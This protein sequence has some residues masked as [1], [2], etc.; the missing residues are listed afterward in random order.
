MS[1][2]FPLPF[3]LLGIHSN[4]NKTFE[5]SSIFTQFFRSPPTRPPPLLKC[6]N[7]RSATSD[8]G[9]VVA[10]LGGYRGQ[11]RIRGANPAMAPYSLARLYPPPNLQR[12]NKPI[13]LIGTNEHLTFK[14]TQGTCRPTFRVNLYATCQKV[15]GA[16]N[17]GPSIKYVT[18]FLTNFDAPSPCHTLSHIPG[19]PKS[20]SHIS[21]S[22]PID[23]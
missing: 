15:I 16:V 23:F 5:N 19:P 14:L 9:W 8:R 11:G 22:S 3:S 17:K 6:N 2:Y 4:F 12:R 1:K 13:R 20:T 18:L 7:G 10:W 21:D